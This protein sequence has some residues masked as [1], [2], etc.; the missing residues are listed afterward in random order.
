MLR[1][2]STLK[3]HFVIG[4]LHYYLFLFLIFVMQV[5]FK[6]KTKSIL[7]NDPKGNYIPRSYSRSIS[8]SHNRII[9]YLNL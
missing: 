7:L 6:K 4:N 8:R 3:Q 5:Q 9:L 1:G 2:Y